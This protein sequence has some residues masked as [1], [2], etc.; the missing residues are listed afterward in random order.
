MLEQVFKRSE[1]IPL[2]DK[3]KEHY[4]TLK[5]T[6]GATIDQIYFY[7]FSNLFEFIEIE[8]T[9]TYKC[10]KT[11]EGE[12]DNRS[13]L[14]RAQNKERL[15]HKQKGYWTRDTPQIREAKR[16]EKYRAEGKLPNGPLN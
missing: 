8:K 16:I 7:R 3:L 5:F 15:D 10:V 13:S 1:I 12:V 9:D 14:F 6:A 4:P 2:Y 11:P